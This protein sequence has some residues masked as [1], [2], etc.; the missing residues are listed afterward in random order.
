MKTLKKLTGSLL[1]IFILF[2]VLL[3]T[4]S[5]EIGLGASVDTDPPSLSIDK[6]IADKVVR[7]DFA[8]RGTWADDG[9]IDKLSA[10]LKRTDGTGSSLTFTGTLK[11]T[12]G[13]RGAGTW[14]INI[15]A[16]T[17]SITDGTYQADI[18]I[19]DATARTTVQSTIFTID[20]TAPVIV[21]TRPTNNDT[22][23]QK[24]TIE[25]QAADTNNIDR[26]EIQLFKDAECT[27]PAGEAPIVLKQVPLSISMDAASYESADENYI[28]E[29]EAADG[30]TKQFSISVPKDGNGSS[31]YCKIYAYDG[32]SRYLGEDD[33]PADDDDKGNKVDYFYLYKDIYT[34]ILQYYK[35]TEL[36]S[37]LNN[38]YKEEAARAVTAVT[39]KA[40][41]LDASK[42][43]KKTS[44]FTL[45]PKNNPTFTV[46]GKSPL[47]LDGKD[48]TGSANEILN[49]QS[50]FIEVSPGLDD[51]PLDEASLKIYVQECDANGKIKT[52]AQKI[53]PPAT[54]E[55][56]GTSYRFNVKL[57]RSEDNSGLKINSCYIFGV[58]GHDQSDAKNQIEPAGR[59]Y[60]FRLAA[61]GNAPSLQVITPADA[62]TYIK[63]D[64]SQ[65]FTGFVEVEMGTPKLLVYKDNDQDESIIKEIEF[66]EGQGVKTSTGYKY[67]FDFDYDTFAQT[68]K[69]ILKA[70]LGGQLSQPIEKTIVYDVEAPI[71]SITKPTTAKKFTDNFGTEAAN[72]YINGQV[73]FFVMLNDKGGSGL[74]TTM[75]FSDS[76]RSRS[77]TS[78]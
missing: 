70:D 31:F 63:K 76:T 69:F 13:K 54:K 19:K 32:S 65:K 75:L 20:N 17:N 64:G 62:I 15:P 74:D 61:S 25:G 45:N 29:G 73:E 48:F 49:G 46:T 16:K 37:I 9:T 12:P 18:T 66:T 57:S 33:T 77:N 59:A 67:S 53:Y 68:N 51:I 28:Y 52:G 40:D 72:A 60:G 5:C 27:Q 21:L 26:I 38:T 35:I 7:G 8:L 30:K 47:A 10:V 55:E 4:L 22:Y 43:Q 24:F 36:Y 11:E 6:G 2:A 42:Y 58:E 50:V 44:Y 14:T 23:G 71:I 1:S 3:S 34:P 78:M 41:L 56:K 39:V